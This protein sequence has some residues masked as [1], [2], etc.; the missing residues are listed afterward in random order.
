MASSN[1]VSCGCQNNPTLGAEIQSILV[2]LN[3]ISE[4]D[5]IKPPLCGSHVYDSRLCIPIMKN[6][7]CN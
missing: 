1:E 3:D 7:F 6:A 5:T 4:I 2:S